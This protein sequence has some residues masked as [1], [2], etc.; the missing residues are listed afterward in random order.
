VTIGFVL[1]RPAK[2]T[3]AIEGPAPSCRAVRWLQIQG[4]R[5]VNRLR[6]TNRPGGRQLRQGIYRVVAR[7]P[8]RQGSIVG[9]RIRKNGRIEPVKASALPAGWCARRSTAAVTAKTAVGVVLAGLLPGLFKPTLTPPAE[10]LVAGGVKAARA[11]SRPIRIGPAR[12]A[13][14]AVKA[15]AGGGTLFRW[16]AIAVVGFLA[17]SFPTVVLAAAWRDLIRR[18]ERRVA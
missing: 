17:L 5:G 6:I 9:F 2:L 16:F 14:G 10:A 15:T 12:L 13:L 8:V 1:R 11:E 3:F 7:G 4:K 18:G